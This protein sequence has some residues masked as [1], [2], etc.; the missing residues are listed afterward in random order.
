MVDWAPMAYNSELASQVYEILKR[1]GAPWELYLRSAGLDLS[2]TSPFTIAAD[3]TRRIRIDFDFPGLEDLCRTTRRGIEPGD[4]AR[5]LLYHVFASP[6]VTPLG[7]EEAHY[8]LPHELDLVENFVYSLAR[9]SVQDLQRRA[10]GELAIVVFAY[11]YA[12][13]INTV[14]RRHAD[15]CFSRTGIARAGNSRARYVPEAR[16]FLP[17]DERNPGVVHVVPCRYA[18]FI[19]ARYYGDPSTIGPER[20]QPGDEETQFWVP[21]HK[22]FDG[23]ECLVGHDLRVHLTAHHVNEKLR[24]IHLALS[25]YPRNGEVDALNVTNKPPYRISE[26]LASFSDP[27][28]PQLLTPVPGNLVQFAKHADGSYATFKV[29]QHF[30]R[31]TGSMFWFHDQ[32][33]ARRGPELVYAGYALVDGEPVYLPEVTTGS[34]EQIYEQGGYDAIHLSDRTA[35]GWIEVRCDQL[36]LDIPTRFSAYSVL[37]APDFFPLVKQQDI[38]EWFEKSAPPE[39]R[40]NIWPES[41]TGPDPLSSSRLSPNLTLTGARFD[42][43]DDTYIAIVG[44][45]RA[46]APAGRIRPTT[47]K[48][49]STL[50]YR[51]SNVFQPGWDTSQDFFFDGDAGDFPGPMHLANYGLSSPF[52]V[53][54]M[55]CAID[56]AFWPGSAPDT[57]RTFGRGP[58]PS[59]TPIPDSVKGWDGLPLP[60]REGNKIIARTVAS[61]DYVK[62]LLEGTLKYGIFASTS[63]EE[64][65]RVTLTMARVYQ[66]LQAT[67]T[68][69][70][71]E[72]VVLS[73]NHIDGA[74]A[75]QELDKRHA[76]AFPAGAFRFEMVRVST[77][78]PVPDQPTLVQADILQE[79]LLLAEPALVL[80]RKKDGS[81]SETRF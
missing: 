29:P 68:A 26:G 12:P 37:G 53:D 31:Y 47:A 18:A 79:A 23:P 44:F 61:A 57:K 11:E 5:S 66:A 28:D 10:G 30:T 69:K 73:F 19:A 76:N 64:Y 67:D 43:A 60:Y 71:A 58:Y 78:A 70:R 27:N 36:I 20:F 81:W 50:S 40:D 4:P 7:A 39:L 80:H 63:L 77:P 52:A 46:A 56:G 15:M 21:L 38:A 14:H 32:R 8:P 33:M 16:G 1:L 48:R 13:A 74:E 35:D 72:W 42:P 54:A 49:E 9:S 25:G 62:E 41:D 55:I 65:I 6:G 51:A 59:V 2:G 34:P 24:R 3:L 22:L 75:G 45:N 17:N